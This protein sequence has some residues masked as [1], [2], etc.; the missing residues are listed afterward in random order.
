M[1]KLNSKAV[2]RRR[3]F[4]PKIFDEPGEEYHLAWGPHNRFTFLRVKEEGEK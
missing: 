3:G 1:L 2:R 4:K